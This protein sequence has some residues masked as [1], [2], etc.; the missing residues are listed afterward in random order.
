MRKDSLAFFIHTPIRPDEIISPKPSPL[1]APDYIPTTDSTQHTPVLQ[2]TKWNPI[3]ITGS[4]RRRS[5][6]K[7]LFSTRQSNRSESIAIPGELVAGRLDYP[8]CL[9]RTQWFSLLTF[10]AGDILFLGAPSRRTPQRCPSPSTTLWRSWT[11]KHLRRSGP[12]HPD[13]W[14]WYVTNVTSKRFQWSSPM[15]MPGSIVWRD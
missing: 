12:T 6:P 2:R 7:P 14:Y 1:G 9:P 15:S 10:W 11:K 5:A 3:L 4:S 13:Y 8:L